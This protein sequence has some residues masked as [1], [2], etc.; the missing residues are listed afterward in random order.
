VS[1]LLAPLFSLLIG[2]YQ[3]TGS[4]D[5]GAITAAY[6]RTFADTRLI[7]LTPISPQGEG[8]SSLSW[9]FLLTLGHAF[10]HGPSGYLIWMKLIA[11]L[12]FFLSL[13]VF[14]CLSNQFLGSRNLAAFSTWILAFSITPLYETFN[15]MEMNLS[16]FLFLFLTYILISNFQPTVRFL[17]GW[18]AASLFIVT[19][20]EAPYMLLG[21]FVG[22][23]FSR[24]AESKCPKVPTP[25]F[26]W[27]LSLASFGS[28]MVMELWR[29]STFGIWM[30]NTVYAK[31]WWPYQPSH[32]WNG[33]LA[34]R[35]GATLEIVVVLFAPLLVIFLLVACNR[36]SFR[37][38][39]GLVSIHRLV[40]SLA[41]CALLFGLIFGKNLGHR[42]R[43]IESLLPFLVLL[44]VTL[45]ATLCSNKSELRLAFL[46]IA[47]LHFGFWS[48]NAILLV[49]RGNGVPIDRFSNEG[50]A[51]DDV[52]QLLHQDTLT[53]MIPDVG[54]SALCCNT[55]RILDLALL[56][57]P[58]LARQGY[59]HFATYFE[60]NRPDVVVAHEGWAEASN[61]YSGGLLRDYSLV[62]ARSVRM[63]VRNDLY[64]ELLSENAGELHHVDDLPFCL[65]GSAADQKFSREKGSCLLLGDTSRASGL[66]EFR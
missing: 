50:L 37:V 58:I 12:F 14:Y 49:H 33:M 62:E 19:R 20:F 54:G 27:T 48:V 34:S 47:A 3:L 7:A 64:S 53:I 28:F 65:G 51:S 45:V 42:G 5:D 23:L 1:A 4:W 18:M 44:L 55:L 46:T 30:P 26:I 6:S 59:S 31:L 25:L 9:F 8:F 41:L 24:E 22:C 56:T 63:F 61:I 40:L 60:L 13:L 29:H 35:G 11:A 36:F 17:L 66:D 57:N 52:R 10:G 16:L 2:L 15:G 38:R 21:L 32:T 39:I 43:M